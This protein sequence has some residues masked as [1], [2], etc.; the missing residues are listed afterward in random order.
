MH[1]PNFKITDE[2][3]YVSD[4]CINHIIGL[5]VLILYVYLHKCAQMC[6]KM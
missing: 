6:I 4:M 3:M 2:C 5:I 1:E